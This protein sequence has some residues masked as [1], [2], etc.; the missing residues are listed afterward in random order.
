MNNWKNKD[1]YYECESD[2]ICPHCDLLVTSD[3]ITEAEHEVEHKDIECDNCGKLFTLYIVSQPVYYSRKQE[4][5]V[6]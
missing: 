6:K 1:W 2:P 4:T 5:E 3:D